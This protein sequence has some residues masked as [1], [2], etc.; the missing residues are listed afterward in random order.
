MKEYSEK[1]K[2]IIEQYEQDEEMMVLLFAQ[3][4]VNHDLE[5]QTLYQEA[6][7]EQL[8]NKKLLK[9]LEDT[10]PKA[11]AEEIPTDVLLHVLQL[12][13]NDDLAFVVQ[14]AA[15]KKRKTAE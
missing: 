15:D 9:V 3:W 7:P 4:C 8:Q 12:F 5:A 14:E 6:Y 10:V 11:E 2:W 13:G 1:E